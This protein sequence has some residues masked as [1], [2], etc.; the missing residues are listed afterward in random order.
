MERDNAMSICNGCGRNDDLRLGYCFSCATEAEVR[1]AKRSTLRHIF[2]GLRNLASLNF[3]Y[4]KYDLQW[5]FERF[6][7]TGD[8]KKDGYFDSQNIPWRKGITL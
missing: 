7:R 8:Y 6:T 4:A 2:N 3:T 5:A 1:V